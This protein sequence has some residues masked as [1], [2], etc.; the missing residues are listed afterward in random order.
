MA[1]EPE[2]ELELKPALDDATGI[3]LKWSRFDSMIVVGD[4]NLAADGCSATILI[5]TPILVAHAK[6][7]RIEGSP[8]GTN[9]LPLMCTCGNPD[10]P[11]GGVFTR[12]K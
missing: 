9:P 12:S 10:T 5:L 2:P 6:S 7:H 1:P 8:Y 4:E 3:A 11:E